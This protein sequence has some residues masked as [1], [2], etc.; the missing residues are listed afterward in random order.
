M[1]VI[2]ATVLTTLLDSLASGKL[3]FDAGMGTLGTEANTVSKAANNDLTTLAAVADNDVQADLALM[4]RTR[5]GGVVAGSL[6]SSLGAYNLWWAIDRHVSGLDT[7]L[8][9][10]NVRVSQALQALGFP[11]SAEQ[12]LPPSVNP[13]ATYAVTGSGAGTYSHVADV[14]TSAYGRAWLQLVTTSVIGAAAIV[15]TVTGL[16]FDGV[17]PTSVSATIPSGSSSG[18]TVNIGTLGTQADSYDSVTGI[19]ITGGTS[20]DTFK[21]VSRVERAISATS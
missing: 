3:I 11:L 10:N 19:S 5:A 8:R 14:D 12:I 16:Q 1:G 21:V 4:F 9:T 13:M 20:G 6:Y 7:F 2:S 18:A 17:T 15:V